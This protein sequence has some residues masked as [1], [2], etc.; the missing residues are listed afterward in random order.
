MQKWGAESMTLLNNWLELTLEEQ[1]Q[2]PCFGTTKLLT[3]AFSSMDRRKSN[4]FCPAAAAMKKKDV[5][6]GVDYSS[7]ALCYP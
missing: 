7:D 2:S 1:Q 3:I 5:T 4:T 6:K